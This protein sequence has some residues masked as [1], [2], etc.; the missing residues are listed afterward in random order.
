MNNKHNW[1]KEFN[2][3]VKIYFKEQ[4][5]GKNIYDALYKTI[6]KALLK[7]LSA[8]L[9]FEII[10][11]CLCI[12]QS[13][14]YWKTLSPECQENIKISISCIEEIC[15]KLNDIIVPILKGIED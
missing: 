7:L 14:K 12:I 9:N 6:K 8:Q 11:N 2:K 4:F 5:L 1:K 10:Y 13:D 15:N 3:Q